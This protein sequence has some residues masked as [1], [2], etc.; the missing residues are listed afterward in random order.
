[1]KGIIIITYNIII[2]YYINNHR[3]LYYKL[4]FNFIKILCNF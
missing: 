4:L 1:M 3:I 2:N